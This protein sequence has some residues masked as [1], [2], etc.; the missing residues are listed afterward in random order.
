[1]SEEFEKWWKDQGS[2]L[3]PFTGHYTSEL[4]MRIAEMAWQVAKISEKSAMPKCVQIDVYK[5][6]A[7][8]ELTENNQDFLELIE[9]IPEWNHHEARI[10]AQRIMDRQSGWIMINKR[11]K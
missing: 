7:F 9:L 2:S 4:V 10:I 5:S 3:K 8:D 11:K 1:M 6:K